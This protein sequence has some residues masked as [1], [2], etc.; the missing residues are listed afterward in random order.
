MLSNYQELCRSAESRGLRPGLAASNRVSERRDPGGTVARWR[1][2]IAL[3]LID[4]DNK[5]VMVEPMAGIDDLERA[6]AALL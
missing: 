6:A 2:I 1:E 5:V 3:E 4:K